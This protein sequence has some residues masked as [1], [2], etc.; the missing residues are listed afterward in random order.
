[1]SVESEIQKLIDQSIARHV[2]TMHGG[3]GTPPDPPDPP[4]PDPPQQGDHAVGGY[5]F[6]EGF[7]RGWRVDE[8][9]NFRSSGGIGYMGSNASG[10]LYVA[11]GLSAG[12]FKV[13]V[14]LTN[15]IQFGAGGRHLFGIAS[16][17]LA[18]RP[19]NSLGQRYPKETTRIDFD[20]PGQSGGGTI[21]VHLY[22]VDGAGRLEEEVRTIEHP[23]LVIGQ[24]AE[25]EVDFTQQNNRLRLNIFAG[26]ERYVIEWPLIANSPGM[27]RYLYVGN[28]DNIHGTE[29]EFHKIKWID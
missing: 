10:L 6:T 4:P 26:T 14:Q 3:G 21:R 18:K 25:F 13:D 15:P 7:W 23:N 12:R 11:D 16:N 27:G 2:S 17:A 8:E 28:M 24:T 19:R 22:N 5:V 29:V 20:R 1:M 9:R